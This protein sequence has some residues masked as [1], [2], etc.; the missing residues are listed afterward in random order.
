MN[1]QKELKNLLNDKIKDIILFGSFVKEGSYNDIDIAIISNENVNIKEEL[2]KIIKEKIDVQNI[3]LDSI[4]NPLWLTLIKE[5][6]SVRKND[7]LFN[8]YKIKPV[9]LYKYN[10]KN[11]NNVQKVQFERGIKSIVKNGEYLTR[12]V[13]I[14]PVS[15]KNEMIDFLKNWNIYYESREFELIPFLRKEAI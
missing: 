3:S 10:L 14:I 9:V 4:Y 13:V 1:Y 5:G 6:F 2:K 7:F 15:M 11:L 12:S 8:F